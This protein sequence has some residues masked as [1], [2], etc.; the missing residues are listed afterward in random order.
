MKLT[1]NK[2]EITLQEA[3]Y[4]ISSMDK[5]GNLLIDCDE[6]V[7]FMVAGMSIGDDAKVAFRERSSLHEKLSVLISGLSE[8]TE[9]RSR[10]L[11]KMYEKY[12][13]KDAGGLTT[14]TLF[15]LFS[16]AETD[17]IHRYDDVQRFFQVMDEDRNGAISRDEWCSYLLYGMNMTDEWRTEFGRR[18]PMHAKIASVV[19]LCLDHTTESTEGPV[20]RNSSILKKKSV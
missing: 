10:A 11:Q 5:D 6:F 16:E 20:K 3:E 17:V 7:D 2:H 18:S 4:F 15:Q 13:D 12:E 1:S 9:R 14:D 19:Q 8:M